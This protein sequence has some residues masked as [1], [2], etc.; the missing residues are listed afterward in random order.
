[1]FETENISIPK[2]LLLAL[3]AGVVAVAAGIYY[4]HLDPN[5]VKQVGLVGGVIAGL[6]VFLL[7]YA[8]SIRPLQ[9]LTRYEKMGV[10][11]LLSNRHDKAYYAAIL[12]KAER[13]VHVMGASCTR[14]VEDFLDYQSDDH[15]LIDALQRNK[16]LRV[17]LLIPDDS[18]ITENAKAR[19][20]MLEQKLKALRSEFGER[21]ELR[22]FP[23]KAQHSF[24]SSDDDLIAGP[25]FDGDESK[26][27][28]A[29]HVS[30]STRFAQKYHEYFEKLW[31]KCDPQH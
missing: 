2:W 15:I 24:V 5:N 3:I 18:H 23:A 30:I 27:A 20:P 19:F 9:N 13:S 11:G 7:T 6:V 29:I 12:S 17:Q 28:P 22:R 31:S 14:F 1:M 21:I 26:Y 4:Y 8:G 16:K 10:R 25:V